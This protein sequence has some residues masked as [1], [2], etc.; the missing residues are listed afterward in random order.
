MGAGQRQRT[1]CSGGVAMKQ[2]RSLTQHLNF[3]FFE[4]GIEN[5]TVLLSRI[6]TL[7]THTQLI[8]SCM[9]VFTCHISILINILYKLLIDKIN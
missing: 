4:V 8:V 3:S 5:K 1:H 9:C 6:K 2:S 7:T